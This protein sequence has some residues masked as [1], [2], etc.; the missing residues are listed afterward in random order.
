[1]GIEDFMNTMSKVIV[2]HVLKN[3]AAKKLQFA[4]SE[5]LV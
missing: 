1:M 5:Y 4:W 2:N 3:R